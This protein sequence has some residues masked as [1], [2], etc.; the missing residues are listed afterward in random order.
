MFSKRLVRRMCEDDF[1][2]S[3]VGTDILIDFVLLA[4]W[5]KLKTFGT[6]HSRASRV[7]GDDLAAAVPSSV[8]YSQIEHLLVMMYAIVYTTLLTY[9]WRQRCTTWSFSYAGLFDRVRRSVT[10]GTMSLEE[11]GA[12]NIVLGVIHYNYTPLHPGRDISGPAGVRA[13]L[14]AQFDAIAPDFVREKNFKELWAPTRISNK[15]QTITASL[16]YL[17]RILRRS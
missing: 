4:T 6:A 16:F 7:S 3:N 14:V 12:L 8:V 13:A 17:A 15:L 2:R 9:G 10:R 11:W 5:P 1:L